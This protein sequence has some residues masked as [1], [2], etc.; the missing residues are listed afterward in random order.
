MEQYVVTTQE[1]DL[2]LAIR[3][4]EEA[5]IYELTTATQSTP[6]EIIQTAS[7]LSD[8][9]LIKL[10]DDQRR[11]LLTD[12]G[13]RVR[14]LLEQQARQPFSSSVRD[15]EV[16]VIADEGESQSAARKAYEA[17]KPEDIDLALDK[18]LEKLEQGVGQ[19]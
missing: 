8:R 6:S 4:D 1:A 3:N 19:S 9:D 17:L 11:I 13:R 18:E 5:T 12:E 16:V 14:R 7:S 10:I 15:S 2:L